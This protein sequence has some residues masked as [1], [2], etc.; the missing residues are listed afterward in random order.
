MELA[1]TKQISAATLLQPEL[2]TSSSNEALK[3]FVTNSKQAVNFKPIFTYPIFGDAEAIY[4]F[5]G[6]EI[7]LCF[8]H[9]TFKP[10]LNIKYKE[11]LDDPELV[12]VKATI[13]KYLPE[14]TIYKDEIKWVDSI[15]EEKKG[16]EIPGEKID[17][18]KQDE[19]VYEIYL[20]DLKSPCGLELH[21]RLQILVLLYIEAGSF[22]DADD[23]L[24]NV[25]VFYERKNGTQ[26]PSIVGFSTAYK[27]WKYPGYQ[28]FD[29]GEDEVRIKISQ[30]IILPMY[31]GKGLGQLFYSHLYDSWLAN[32]KIVE[33]VVEDPNESFDDM[34]DR[35]DLKKLA[36]SEFEFD[37][38]VAKQIDEEWVQQTRKKLKF[39]K[40][41][42]AR[43]LELIL[44][45]KLKYTRD[46]SKADVRLF[47]KNRLYKKNK[48]GLEALDEANRKDKLQTAY[49]VLEDD[50]YRILGDLKLPLKRKIGQEDGNDTRS[51]KKSKPDKTGE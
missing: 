35:A 40:R 29:Q 38:V 26:E 51:K 44:L 30:F 49:Q 37:K 4:G 19:S 23:D 24:W 14:D 15:E 21:K 31:Q 3:L 41:Q 5:R 9:Y 18:F 34:R 36:Q 27:Y 2:W 6:L 25:Y 12:D 8:D 13:D 28:K 16:Y 46:V 43:L 20:L 42:F 48:E 7:F 17:S 45:Y 47:I 33:I 50:Y 22:I 11:K 39:E 32:D 1:D 10:F